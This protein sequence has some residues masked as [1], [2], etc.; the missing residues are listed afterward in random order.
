MN[1]IKSAVEYYPDDYEKDIKKWIEYI[2][3][4]NRNAGKLL[5]S[6]SF[7]GNPSSEELD[8]LYDVESYYVWLGRKDQ[9]LDDVRGYIEN[10]EHGVNC[11]FEF[12]SRK[13]LNASRKIRH[14]DSR[15][16]YNVIDFVLD[17][18][19]HILHVVR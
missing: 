17:M 19:E 9:D 11:S 5:V 12:D 10:R 16:E 3:D 6:L 2:R 8:I 7:K 14:I 1:N 4:G 18:L 13:I 15:K